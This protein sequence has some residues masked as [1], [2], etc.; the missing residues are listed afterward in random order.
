VTCG[1]LK[2]ADQ[3]EA[4]RHK[5]VACQTGQE[6]R[7]DSA[8]EQPGQTGVF[9]PARDRALR[10]VAAEHVDSYRQL[11]AHRLAALPMAVPRQRARKRAVSQALSELA[12]Q[13]P[14]RYRQLYEQELETA[15]S[16]PLPIR[17]GRPPGTPDQLS[18][19][20]TSS[21]L[22]WRQ[23]GSPSRRSK[24]NTKG[25]RQRAEL[26]A[27]RE[28]AAEL[29]AEGRS[30]ATVADELGVARQT[31]TQWRARWQSGGTAALR[32]R[33]LGR[34]PAVPDSRL[35]AIEQALLKG[36][37]AHGF[38][39]DM[40]TS[41][42][43][44]VV[45]Q[46]MTGVQL[47]RKAVQRLLRERLGRRF[48]PATSGATVVTAAAQ[49]L[50]TP[51][52]ATDSLAAIAAA[53]LANL[54]DLPAGLPGLARSNRPA[55]P[56]ERRD[57][58]AQAWRDEPGITDTALAE[59]FGVSRRTLQRD[60][61]AL[62]ERGIQRH[63][64][65]RR[66]RSPRTRAHYAAIYQRFLAWL[67]DELGRPP[68]RHDLSGD[69]LARWIA[70]RASVGGHGGGGLSSASLR[71]ECSALRQLARHAGRPELAAS[72]HA[73][74]QQAPPPETISPAQYERLLLEPDLTTPLHVRDR[75][76]LRLLGDVGLRPS[77]L[78]A[79][80]IE[81]LAWSADGQAAVQLK[82]ARGQ[83]RVV[84]LTPQ[85]T[86]ALAGWFPHH[87]DWQPDGRGRELAAEA[88]LFVALGPPKS[89]RQAITESGLLR[90]VLRHAQQAGI[91]AHLRYPYVLRHYWATQQVARGI[92]PAQLQARGGWRDR[93]SAQAYFQR[94]PAAAAL[95]AALDLDR[96]TPPA[97]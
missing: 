87:P 88:P 17:P 55:T 27:V 46:R 3:F 86:A 77:E 80:K 24:R 52:S 85:A 29:F 30:A 66:R 90:Q 73:S 19:A 16:E 74:R 67:A 31:A 97:R 78:C 42:R 72:L 59:R 96:E 63:A 44:A 62:Q 13:H 1:Q 47:G 22:T 39:S 56:A 12:K 48:Q 45:V 68:T 20:S 54:E 64:A 38:D 58:I 9:A 15:R 53:A 10:R 43:V 82:V 35:P 34:Q 4:G 8:Q 89:A 6:H 32:N 69:V 94:P 75:A 2:S 95:A 76:M 5:C 14:E 79:L 84:Q 91:P 18:L 49:P 28:R 26:Q 57:A 71:L 65:D 23:D 93:R 50:P 92:T 41:A 83:G 25:A 37:E 33:R 60:T 40:W 21:G 70:Q 36:A 51:A 81:D 61:Q 7:P 11:Y